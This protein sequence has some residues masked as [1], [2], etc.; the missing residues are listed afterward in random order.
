MGK[1]KRK[2]ATLQKIR[3]VDHKTWQVLRFQISKTLTS[4]III[5][6]QIR[7]KMGVIKH[8]IVLIKI[9]GY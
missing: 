3:I 5:M 1:V 9:L 4:T 6:L 2:V 7:L 8:V